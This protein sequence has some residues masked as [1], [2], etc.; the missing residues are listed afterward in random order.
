ML[1]LSPTLSSQKSSLPWNQSLVPQM[2]GTAVL[3]NR[4]IVANLLLL[5]NHPTLF[6][7]VICSLE[8]EEAI[9]WW[10]DHH[11]SH[12][13]PKTR[14]LGCKKVHFQQRA[15]IFTHRSLE[16]K[17]SPSPPKFFQEFFWEFSCSLRMWNPLALST[18]PTSGY[19]RFKQD[20][21]HHT[22][23]GPQAPFPFRSPS[24]LWFKAFAC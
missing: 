13:G 18:Q 24:M 9:L 3:G 20:Q 4:Y 2:S 19:Y 5:Q 17:V 1:K 7:D 11:Q 8:P 23:Q 6:F 14:R 22:I 21:R 15:H 12:Q 10:K 16:L